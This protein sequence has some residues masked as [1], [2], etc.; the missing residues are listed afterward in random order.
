MEDKF[1]APTIMTSNT[2][3][4]TLTLTVTLLLLLLLL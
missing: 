2:I 1:V 4:D 3:P